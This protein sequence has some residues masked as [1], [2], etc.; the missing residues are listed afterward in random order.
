MCLN[1]SI[2]I[3]FLLFYTTWTQP[4]LRVAT[5]HCVH[6]ENSN[7]VSYRII[8]C[9][10]FCSRKMQLY[11][12]H[13]SFKSWCACQLKRG[14]YIAIQ[15]FLTQFTLTFGRYVFQLF[16]DYPLVAGM[17]F[18]AV[19]FSSW[20]VCFFEN[21]FGSLEVSI[22]KWSV[23]LRQDLLLNAALSWRLQCLCQLKYIKYNDVWTLNPRKSR[24]FVC[25]HGYLCQW[26][27]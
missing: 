15:Y 6:A 25:F 3:L 27:Q 8:K 14:P 20:S 1:R 22:L 10:S 2:V 16:L 19:W 12:Q 23:G 21:T 17:S 5:K 13:A 9:Q 11:L 24:C 18:T 26:L 7:G 4:F